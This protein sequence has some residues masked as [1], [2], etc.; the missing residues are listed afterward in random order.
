MLRHNRKPAV[1][2]CRGAILGIGYG[3]LVNQE[4]LTQG[5]VDLTDV[6]GGVETGTEGTIIEDTYY[7]QGITVLDT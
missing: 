3:W 5:F 1:S 7:R 6:N 4:N 2:A